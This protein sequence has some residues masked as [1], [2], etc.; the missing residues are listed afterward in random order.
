[1]RTLLKNY[2]YLI[3]AD[4]DIFFMDMAKTIEWFIQQAKIQGVDAH[5]WVPQDQLG[6]GRVLFSNAIFIVKNSVYGQFLLDTWW[7]YGTGRKK[8]CKDRFYR[9]QQVG[10]NMNLDMPWMWHSIIL[11]YNWYWNKTT[12]CLTERCQ[13]T[14]MAECFRGYFFNES[15]PLSHLPPELGHVPGPIIFSKIQ[16]KAPFDT[17]LMVQGN[18]G[19]YHDHSYVHH[20]F[21]VHA[22]KGCAPYLQ[23]L[24]TTH[25][26]CVSN[27]GCHANV[28][29]DEKTGEVSTW[30]RCENA[31][32]LR[33]VAKVR[34]LLKALEV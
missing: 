4:A 30:A 14:S 10:H 3:W 9:T 34:R 32:T 1:M 19:A 26:L 20:A 21:S 12:D 25:K 2:D 6:L 22:K 18:W 33:D 11:L 8:I 15:Y 31:N 5:V 24:N 7:D 13:T 27:L 16:T 28:T 17:G 29:R 23:Y